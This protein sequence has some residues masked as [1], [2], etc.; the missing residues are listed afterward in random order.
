MIPYGHQDIDASDIDAVTS[1]LRS[2]WL[3]QGP[4]IEK[5]ERAVSSYCGSRFGIAVNSGTSALHIACMACGVT[6]GDFVWTSPITFVASANCAIYC[7]ASVD[8]VDIDPVSYNISIPALER[9]LIAAEKNGTLPKVVIAVHFSGQPCEMTQLSQ[10]AAKYHFRII[11]DASH[12][13]G[14]SYRHSPIGSCAHSDITVFSF[15]PVKI[16]TTAEG[17]MAMT[18]DESLSDALSLLRSH[19]ITRDPD[20]FELVPDGPWYYEQQ[21]LGYNY[22]LTDINAALGLSQMSRLEKFIDRRRYLADR[23][24]QALA[25]LPL[26]LPAQAVHSASSWHL[27]VIRLQLNQLSRNRKQIFEA[28]RAAG[29][30]VNVHYIPVH[31]QPFYRALGFKEGDFPESEAYYREAITLPLYPGLSDDQHDAVVRALENALA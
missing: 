20:D 6:S 25:N 21:R 19:G 26:K 3:T 11:E 28:L 1:V 9:K 5:F 16:V 4:T 29:I 7:G 31:L 10:L 22:R 14:A 13:L 30:G 24:N 23:Y 12:A 15:H 8:F 2:D 27:Y 18:N 17:G